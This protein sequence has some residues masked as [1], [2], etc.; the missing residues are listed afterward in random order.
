MVSPQRPDRAADFQRYGLLVRDRVGRALSARLAHERALAE[1]LSASAE[2]AEVHDAL[3]SLC[4]RG[5]KRLRSVLLSLAYDALREPS[6]PDAEAVVDACVAV[7]LLQAYLLIHDDWM[8]GDDMRRGGPTVHRSL[9]GSLGSTTLGEHVAVL[10][11]DFASAMAQAAFVSVPLP[12]AR[13]VLGV[14]RLADIQRAVVAGQI[15]DV[16]APRRPLETLTLAAVERLHA[17][18]TGSYT[19]A[20]PLALGALLAGAGPE[21]VAALD[22]FAHPLGVAFQLRDDL[23]GVFGEPEHTGKARFGDLREGKRTSLVAALVQVP[24]GLA[25]ASEVLGRRDATDDECERVADAMVAGGCK[26]SVEARVNELV[27]LARSRVGAIG[28]S[29]DAEGLLV[30]AGHALTERTR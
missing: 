17:N 22:A 2:L 8:D 23:L 5:G 28:L 19:V 3:A 14:T 24:G 26:A 13:L 27:E 7:E 25:L 20:G 29:P 10:A 1:T 4:T 18:K 11:G 12:S 16:C 21:R 6:A 9:A 15:D 30:A